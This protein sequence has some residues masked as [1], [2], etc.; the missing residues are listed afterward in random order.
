[1]EVKKRTRAP[2]PPIDSREWM[3]AEEVAAMIGCSKATVQRFANGEYRQYPRLPFIPCGIKK[4][5]YRK[6]STLA[7]LAEL[8]RMAIAK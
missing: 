3:S 1:M 6:E 4:R 5:V 8:E 2:K 7:W